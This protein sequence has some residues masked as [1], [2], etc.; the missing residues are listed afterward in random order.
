MRPILN[1]QCLNTPSEIEIMYMHIHF[2][3]INITAISRC[4][5]RGAGDSDATS[6]TTH[7]HSQNKKKAQKRLVYYCGLLDYRGPSVSEIGGFQ[8]RRSDITDGSILSTG[9]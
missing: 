4:A 7:T 5:L 9:I 1:L 6:V 8:L 3:A 2:V